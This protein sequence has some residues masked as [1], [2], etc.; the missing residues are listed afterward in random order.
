[1]QSLL[2]YSALQ[3][4]YASMPRGVGSLVAFLPRAAS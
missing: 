1:M 2:G 3:S 4:G